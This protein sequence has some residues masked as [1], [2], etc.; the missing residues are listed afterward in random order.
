MRGNRRIDTKPELRVRSLLHK[1]GLRFRKDLAI[2]LPG[3]RVCPD[4]VF[5]RRKVAIFIDGCFWHRC[6]QHGNRPRANTEYWSRKLAHNVDRDKRVTVALR[7][8]GW[9]VI[10]I[11]EHVPPEEAAA[12]IEAGVRSAQR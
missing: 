10:R 12:L 8:E 9:T 7:A 4:I 2:R 11:W 5:T 6:P 1:R 3:L